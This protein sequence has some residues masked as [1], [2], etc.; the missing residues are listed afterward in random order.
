MKS[1]RNDIDEQLQECL[2]KNSINEIE[3]IYIDELREI[4]E[5][6]YM[7]NYFSNRIELKSK[8]DSKYF[9][10]SMSC[11]IEAF[12]LL[13]NNYS[14]G[15]SLV[16]RSA[17]ENFIK[18]VIQVYLIE[19]GDVAYKINDR[20]YNANKITLDKI[21]DKYIKEQLVIKSKSINSRME[22]EYKKLSGISHS[23]VAESENNTLKYFEDLDKMNKQN[24]LLVI[25]HFI[26]VAQ[27]FFSFSLIMCEKSFKNWDSNELK[28]ILK[29]VFGSSQTK[30]YLR[31]IKQ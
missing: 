6:I 14:R 27:C 15:S 1:F 19:T 3:K 4:F 23:L 30:T 8:F 18:H 20:S 24:I 2:N 16:L 29:V 10:I 26:N 22:T 17:L 12:D 31:K 7:I 25:E 9:N 11:L 21:S 13:I 28:Q 5:C